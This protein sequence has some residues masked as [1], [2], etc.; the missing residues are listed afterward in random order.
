MWKGKGSAVFD[1]EKQISG[2]RERRD[3]VIRRHASH[4]TEASTKE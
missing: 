2:R 4:L 3:E 1:V